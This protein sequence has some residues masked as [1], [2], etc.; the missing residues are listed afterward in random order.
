VLRRR[1]LEVRVVSRKCDNER[2]QTC[3]ALAIIAEIGLRSLGVEMSKLF[4][5]CA[6]R[7]RKG[8]G[9]VKMSVLEGWCNVWEMCG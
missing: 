5:A 6:Q 1:N 9:G 4:F 3:A 7:R 2:S 8:S